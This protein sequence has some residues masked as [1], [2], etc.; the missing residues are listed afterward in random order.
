[1]RKIE[2]NY[3][4][5]CKYYKTCKKTYVIL[6]TSHRY[7]GSFLPV[8]VIN[9]TEKDD[10]EYDKHKHVSHLKNC[11]DLVKEWTVNCGKIRKQLKEEEESALKEYLHHGDKPSQDIISYSRKKSREKL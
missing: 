8:E 11:P 3:E 4:Y 9:G 1:M 2:L 7:G 6:P 10:L 5:R